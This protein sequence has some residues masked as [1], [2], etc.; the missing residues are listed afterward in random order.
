MD[1]IKEKVYDRL[2]E[3]LDIEGYPTEASVDFKEAKVR[4]L[5]YSTLGP[6]LARFKYNTG[7]DIHLE[8]EKDIISVDVTEEKSVLIVEAKRASTGQA[9]SSVFC[10]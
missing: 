9:I 7:R 1:A 4:D 5:F 2:V 10:H 6:I 3:Y 8:R